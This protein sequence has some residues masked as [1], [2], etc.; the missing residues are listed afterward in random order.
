MPNHNQKISSFEIP[1]EQ[2]KSKLFFKMA[3]IR[4]LENNRYLGKP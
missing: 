4:R 1:G 2:K 3:D